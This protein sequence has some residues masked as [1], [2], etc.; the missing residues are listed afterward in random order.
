MIALKSQEAKEQ[1]KT[2]ALKL[3]KKVTKN[4]VCGICGHSF[5]TRA[6]FDRFCAGCREQ[7]ELYHFHEWLHAS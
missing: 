4:R 1:A 3:Q 2:V 5:S 6:K 7:S